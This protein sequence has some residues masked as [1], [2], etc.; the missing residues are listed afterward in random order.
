MAKLPAHRNRPGENMALLQLKNVL[1]LDGANWDAFLEHV[2]VGFADYERR[3]G[4][5]TTTS[6]RLEDVPEEWFANPEA[7]GYVTIR[8]LKSGDPRLAA[9]VAEFFLRNC[10]P[11]QNILIRPPPGIGLAWLFLARHGL[12]SP[13][14]PARLVHLA[15]CV[16][17]EFFQGVTQD[18]LLLLARLML[19]AK[20][21]P[22]AWDLHALLGAVDQAD[23]HARAPF[24]LF[25]ALMA[26]DWL[27]NEV[28]EEFCLGLLGCSSPQERLQE[29]AAA[30]LQSLKADLKR[31]TLLP[32]V[33][34][35]VASL[36]LRIRVPGLQ[37]HA[38]RAL[39]EVLGRSFQDVVQEFFLRDNAGERYG[40][41]IDL[42][43]LDAVASRAKEMRSVELREIL[44]QAVKNGSAVVRQAAYRTGLEHLGPVFVQPALE[45]SAKVVRN[46]AIKALAHGA[47]KPGR[48]R[49]Q[50]GR[51]S[52]Q[53]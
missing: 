16:P 15:M 11:G 17:K 47:P 27:P 6:L 19:E 52:G 51:S 34:L 49:K 36:G 23:I 53:E 38:V 12:P 32:T 7:L 25:D 24:H 45:D 21:P 41:M 13:I 28:K 14:E 29:R 43:V 22:E 30:V 20:G 10:D 2:Q 35:N 39:V 40:D 46:W 44:N 8:V 31:I 37:R 5:T 42:G 3:Y 48:P 26:A 33:L 4:Y 50:G 9:P 1:K 18:D